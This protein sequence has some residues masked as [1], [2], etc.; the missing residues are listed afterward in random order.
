VFVGCWE[1]VVTH[2]PI[3]YIHWHNNNNTNT[4]TTQTQHQQQQHKH[5]NNN[6]ISAWSFSPTL[7]PL[8]STP[9]WQRKKSYLHFSLH[10]I[11]LLSKA[12]SA[13]RKEKEK[14]SIDALRRQK[15]KKINF[16]AW[17]GGVWC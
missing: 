17:Y 16:E 8:F 2:Q 13:L 4:T 1:S 5:N 11:V 10:G 6:N 15:E 14:K 9:A 7:T 12:R 3:V